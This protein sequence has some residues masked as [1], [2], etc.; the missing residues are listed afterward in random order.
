MR[1]LIVA[2]TAGVAVARVSSSRDG[3][4]T[5]ELE[6]STNEFILT[7]DIMPY[8]RRKLQK[9]YSTRSSR[10]HGSGK[11]GKSSTGIGGGWGKSGKSGLDIGDDDIK[12]PGSDVST[13][14]V[15][16]IRPFSRF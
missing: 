6:A 3:L 10:M 11:S 9:R 2:V 13:S 16:Y 14:Q 5:E 1:S 4:T 12:R 7:N 15:H 8:P